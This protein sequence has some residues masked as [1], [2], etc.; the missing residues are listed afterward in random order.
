MA[1][2]DSN[3]FADPEENP[4]GESAGHAGG[5]T[6]GLDDYNPFAA[7]TTPPTATLPPPPPAQT[8]AA[9]QPADTAARLQPSNPD[10]PPYQSVAAQQ[11]DTS[12][13]QRRQE[14]LERK[15]AE[16]Q[17]KEQKLRDRTVNGA[18]DNNFPP[19]PACCPVKPC[20]YQDFELDIPPEFQRVAKIAYYTWIVRSLWLVL[21]FFFNI[22]AFALNVS[23]S[24]DAGT[25][26][27]LS[28]L[29]LILWPPSSFVCWY[30]PAYKAL[31]SDSSIN[32]FW[33]FIVTAVQILVD[34]L[35]FLGPAATGYLGMLSAI[36]YLNDQDHGQDRRNMGG[37]MLILMFGSAALL[38]L[39]LYLLITIHKY[40]RG[41][42]AS[43][44]QAQSEFTSGM[45][46][47]ENVRA[48]GAQIASDAAAGAM[49][50]A[51]SSASG[52]N[53]Y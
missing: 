3:P 48:A 50:G 45:L 46:K 28:I 22:G 37:V 26:F 29:W 18:K 10:P 27:G 42:G 13:L 5:Q 52:G 7:K 2:L 31:R 40:Y 34:I 20:F 14:E 36:G 53:R 9:P 41:T 12:E 19:L 25:S 30:R 16:L 44:Q 39:D 23:G 32:Y 49:A 38:I 11:V 4:F 33:F 1:D 17:E 43:F 35:M 24:N 15:A 51:A 6:G 47:N 21:N 8:V